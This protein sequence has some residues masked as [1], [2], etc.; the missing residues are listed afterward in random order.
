MVT[1]DRSGPRRV[2]RAGGGVTGN[3]SQGRLT[4][5]QVEV[6]QL[7]FS[8]AASGGFLL[9]GGAALLAHGLTA[10]PTQD[11]DFFTRPDAGDVVLAR[12]QFLAAA[13][14]RGWTV[15]RVHEAG[16]FCRLVVHGPQDLL[17]DLALDSAPGRPASASIAGPTFAPAELASRKVI[18]LFDRAAARDF[19]DV[20]ALTRWFTTTELLDL[21]R[22]VD[23]GFDLGVFTDMLKHVVR[24]ADVDLSLGDVDRA[25][26]RAFFE[27]WIAELNLGER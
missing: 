13:G 27:H 4:E 5:F 26:L 8:L 15:D 24:Y 17:V 14:E 11:L 2:G 6:A 25:A 18:A 10:R 23:A 19:V 12:D 7:F 21:A 9:A 16:T 20:Y 3:G 1:A 22:E